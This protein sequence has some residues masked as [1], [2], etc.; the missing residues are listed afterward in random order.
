MKFS[1]ILFLF[2]TLFANEQE[3][4]IRLM[5]ENRLIPISVS[6]EGGETHSKELEQIF[7]NDLN[8]N[9]MTEVAREKLLSYQAK[10]VFSKQQVTLFIITPTLQ[11]KG[12]PL[13]LSGNLSQDR[14]VI[15]R[16]SDQV[17]KTLFGQEGIAQTRVL[18]TVRKKD[19]QKPDSWLSFVYEADQDGANVK[20][21]T[22]KSGYCVTPAFIPPKEGFVS[23]S[24]LYVGYKSGLPKIY[25]ATFDGRETERLI[26]LGGNQLMPAI[27]RNRDQIAFVCDVTGNPDLFLLSFDPATGACEKPRKIFSAPL[28]TEGTPTFS[29]DG[30]KIAFVSNKDGAARIWVMNIPAIGTPLK[31]I[32]PVLLSKIQ[33]ECTAPSWSPDGKKIAYCSMTSGIRQI[34][35]HDLKTGEDRQ[36]TK[37]GKNKENP[38]WAQNSLCLMYNTSDAN[39]CQLYK[40]LLK[41]LAV[42]QVPIAVQGEKHFPNWEIF[43]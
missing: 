25:M 34:W 37:G 19:P 42:A 15:H 32:H 40:V 43:R 29:P 5:T 7:I 23:G 30:N 20:Q 22:K 28:A 17:Y 33:R 2:S 4:F 11:K 1:F 10:L 16:L 12:E 8:F 35:V 26:A 36:I 39:D 38:T 21:V 31:N 41:N 6:F 9:G 18:F 24:F 13:A 27:S 14:K 3:L